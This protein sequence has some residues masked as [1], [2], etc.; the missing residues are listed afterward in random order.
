MRY[1]CRPSIQVVIKN[2]PFAG[3][4][5]QRHV[6]RALQTYF[7]TDS[8]AKMVGILNV[9]KKYGIGYE[10]GSSSLGKY[11]PY[12]VLKLKYDSFG[13]FLTPKNKMEEVTV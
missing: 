13:S 1:E 12:D 3:K 4:V 2:T 10:Y 11:K 6:A 9:L 5:A 8:V 7:T